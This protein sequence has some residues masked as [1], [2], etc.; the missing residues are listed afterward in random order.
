MRHGR[1][2]V[3][4]GHVDR[5]EGPDEVKERLRV[6]LATITGEMTI[7]EASAALGVGPSRVHEM[8]REALQGALAGLTP[9][10]AG[11]PGKEPDP[12]GEEVKRLEAKISDLETDL[13]AALVRTEIALAMPHL[14]TKE[15]KKKDWAKPKKGP[16]GR[17]K[18]R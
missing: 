2:P 11:R 4:V 7:E 3:G 9:G 17:K 8:R 16:K 13:Q 18:R 6:L 5:L 1:P 14:F 10:R 12:A 15:S